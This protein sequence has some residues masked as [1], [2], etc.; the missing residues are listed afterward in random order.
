VAVHRRP[1]PPYAAGPAAARA[2]A[3]AMLDVSDGLLRD[4]GRIAEASGVVLDLS[5]DLLAGYAAALRPVAAALGADPW[6]W[7]LSGGEDHGLRPT[8]PPGAL[9]ASSTVSGAGRPAAGGP[10]GRVPGRP[11]A[12]AV[13]GWDHFRP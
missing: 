5:R 12:S 9:R 13:P 3:S 4:A 11:P 1:T 10:S 7:V 8:S 2:Q 6:Q